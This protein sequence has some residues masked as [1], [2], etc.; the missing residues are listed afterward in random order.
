[1]VRTFSGS[2]LWLCWTLALLDTVTYLLTS[3][4]VLTKTHTVAYAGFFMGVCSKGIVSIDVSSGTC[5]GK[6]V[7][8]LELLKG[9]SSLKFFMLHFFSKNFDRYKD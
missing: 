7:K 4:I 8:L 6:V 5:I 2:V 1:M 3:K 9:H